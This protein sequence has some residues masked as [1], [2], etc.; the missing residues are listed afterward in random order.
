MGHSVLN[1][2]PLLDRARRR[3]RHDC[4]EQLFGGIFPSSVRGKYISLCAMI[5][6]IGVPVT[7]VVS[8]F[9][10]PLG[11]WGWRLVFVWGR[12]VSFISFYPPA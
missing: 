4:D 12:S 10:I 8:A 7:N 5:G 6:L 9:V 1:D 3:G 11:S 2:F